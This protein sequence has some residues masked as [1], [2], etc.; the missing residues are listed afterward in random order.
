[1]V[2]T[3]MNL[4]MELYIVKRTKLKDNDNEKNHHV[5]IIILQFQYYLEINTFLNMIVEIHF[6]IVT[7]E[8]LLYSL[9][10]T[11]YFEV[12]ILNRTTVC[13]K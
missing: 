1:M 5:Q 2:L 4:Y 10:N 6:Y 9:R 12:Y 3:A 11:G 8:V 7:N 13:V